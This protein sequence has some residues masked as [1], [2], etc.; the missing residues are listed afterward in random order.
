MEKLL[1]LKNLSAGYHMQVLFGVNLRIDKGEVVALMGPNGAGKST[2]LKAI[3]GLIQHEGGVFYEGRK[4]HPLP[5][6]LVR[7]GVAYVPQGRRVFSSLT[8]AE[9]L[10]MGG[11]FLHD[12]REIKRRIEGIYQIFPVLKEKKQALGG[13]LSGGQQQL[14]AIARGLMTEPKIL[15]LDEPT[16]GLSPKVVKEVFAKIREINERR[17][18]AILIVEHNLKSV[19]EIVDRAYVLNHGKIVCED[20]PQNIVNSGILEQIFSGKI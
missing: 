6:D 10:E 1:E 12:A 19:L 14:L 15:L 13:E 9:N 7:M 11:F 4:I 18:T 3:F 8:V 2:V 20:I 16:L 5:H 17:H